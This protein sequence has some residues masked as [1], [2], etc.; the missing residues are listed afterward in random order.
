MTPDTASSVPLGLS[1]ARP[2]VKDLPQALARLTQSEQELAALQACHADWMRAVSHDLRAPVR[3]ITSY[4]PLLR[5]TL[6]GAGLSGINAEEAEQFLGVM[7]QAASRLGR[8]LEGT[9]RLA[10]VLSQPLRLQSVDLVQMAAEVRASL[11]AA[12]SEALPAMHWRLPTGPLLLQ[13]DADLLRQML[14]ALLDNALKFSR[15]TGQIEL[16]FEALPDGR[17]RWQVQDNGLGFD[18]ARAA[19]VF[20]LFQRLHREGEFAGIGVGLA[21]AQAVARR[22]GAEL[23]IDSVPGQGC[24][25]TVDWPGARSLA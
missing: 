23:A 19:Q 11:L 9:L 1:M 17:L 3:H 22:H 12:E 10:R 24:T 20:G 21:L 18:G 16:Q 15:G 14:E 5:E 6:H 13:A 25:V 2:L 4:A 7:E 8:M